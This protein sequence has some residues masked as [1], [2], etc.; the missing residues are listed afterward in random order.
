VIA[1][2]PNLV[3]QT[4]DPTAHAE[5]VAIREAC[6][7]L[8]SPNLEGYEAYVMAH[9]C[10]MCL[11]AL[12]YASPDRVEYLVTR[13]E[14]GRYYTDDQKYFEFDNFYAEFE[15]PPQERRLPMEHTPVEG[16]QEV[17]RYWQRLNS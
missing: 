9:P 2:S 14:E 17:Y 10:P 1:E 11:G 12:Y 7:R 4:N 6:Q 15:K 5:V 8:G 16:G 13:E 3:A